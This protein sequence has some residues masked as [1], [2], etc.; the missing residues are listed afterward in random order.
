MRNTAR[1]QRDRVL[2]WQQQALALA[3]VLL[4]QPT[5]MQTLA[6]SLGVFVVALAA[7]LLIIFVHRRLLPMLGVRLGDDW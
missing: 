7:G 1:S 3:L 4:L 5:L 2:A 6:G